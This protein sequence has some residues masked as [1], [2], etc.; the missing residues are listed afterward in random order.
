MENNAVTYNQAVG[1]QNEQFGIMPSSEHET[2]SLS[3]HEQV[4]DANHVEQDT[5][6][7]KAKDDSPLPENWRPGD[8]K[9]SSCGDH[10]FASRMVCRRCDTRKDGDTAKGNWRPGDWKCSYCGDH[11]FA[12]RMFCRTCDAPKRAQRPPPRPSD[13]H[14]LYCGNLNKETT[15]DSLR[16]IMLQF[17]EITDCYILG[18]KGNN[19]GFGFVVYKSEDG[20]KSALESSV[21]LDG[22]KIKIEK[23]M[24]R[25][26]DT[27]W[28]WGGPK[29]N[30][31]Q[32]R[33]YIGNV[34][35][36][37]TEDQLKE[38]LSQYGEISDCVIMNER[39][40]GFVTFVD[41][42]S[43]SQALRA[44][45]VL[46]GEKLDVQRARPKREEPYY[47][48]APPSWSRSRYDSYFGYDDYYG[49][50]SYGYDRGYGWGPPRGGPPPWS[51]SRSRDWDGPR[52]GRRGRDRS[53]R[54][55]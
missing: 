48:P 42:E 55:W 27:E 10:N 36:S 37:T 44:D 3:N 12:S 13:P 9:C 51:R 40:F 11:Q 7:E 30:D 16:D 43:T 53:P 54:R 32:Q 33:L 24:C 26:D 22:S 6:P 2:N 1:G 25:S 19:K 52:Y 17:G 29:R 47:P 50:D 41:S 31:G 35:K 14:K 20:V 49:Y 8:W 38:H 4:N 45:I 5:K 21:E 46:N 34:S 18:P 15:E 39:G 23:S 28:S